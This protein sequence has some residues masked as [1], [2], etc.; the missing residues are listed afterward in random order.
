MKGVVKL[1]NAAPGGRCIEGCCTPV[2]IEDLPD[3]SSMGIGHGYVLCN[4]RS[5]HVKVL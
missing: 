4:F 3:L 5:D 2:A 1:D